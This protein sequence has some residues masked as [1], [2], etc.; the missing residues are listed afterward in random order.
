MDLKSLK[1][2]LSYSYIKLFQLQLN[3]ISSFNL[4]TRVAIQAKLLGNK[5]QIHITEDND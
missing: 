4:T 5:K 1:I 2:Q 3:A